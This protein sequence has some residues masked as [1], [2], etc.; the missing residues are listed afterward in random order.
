MFGLV[1][2]SL[3][4]AGIALVVTCKPNRNG[5]P[6][7]PQHSPIANNMQFIAVCTVLVFLDFQHNSSIQHSIYLLQPETP[8]SS[9]P[10]VLGLETALTEKKYGVKSHFA[11]IVCLPSFLSCVLD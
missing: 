3:M 1:W 2:F 9:S 10:A 4:I 7:S 11:S 6:A 8:F 5:I